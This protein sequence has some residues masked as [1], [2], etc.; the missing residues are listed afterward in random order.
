[1]H[2]TDVIYFH[3]V[4]TISFRIWICF[5][6]KV[7]LVHL[8][9]VLCCIVSPS[10]IRVCFNLNTKICS[11]WCFWISKFQWICCQFLELMSFVAF[12]FIIMYSHSC[13]SWFV[14]NGVFF[15][16]KFLRGTGCWVQWASTIGEENSISLV[17]VTLRLHNNC[18]ELYLPQLKEFTIFS[19]FVISDL[20]EC[21]IFSLK[22][23]FLCPSESNHDSFRSGHQVW[24]D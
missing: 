13:M 6:C 10:L 20:H 11:S 15:L 1:M 22:F 19:G 5:T 18:F 2:L 8:H 23:Q 17:Q 7:I 21:A 3:H 9:L 4:A 16:G 14:E 12:P 24:M